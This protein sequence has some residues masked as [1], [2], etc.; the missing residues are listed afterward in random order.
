MSF[1][2]AGDEYA[3]P[4]ARV[5]ELAPEAGITPLPATPPFVLGLLSLHGAAVPVLDLQL[6]FRGTAAADVAHRS[7]LVLQLPIHGTCRLVGVAIDA[8]GRV[9]QVD[10]SQLQPPPALDTVISLEFLTG[11]LEREGRFLYALDVDRLLRADEAEAVAQLAEESAARPAAVAPQARRAF[12]SV[13]VA[14]E[15]CAVPL[16]SLDEI[17]PCGPIAR[18]P[19]APRHVLG[20]TNV[21]GTIVPVVDLP[22]RFLLQGAAATEDA[23]LLL[24]TPDGRQP[25]AARVDAVDGL[26]HV[27]ASEVDATPPFGARF[28]SEVVQAV[29]PLGGVF[30]PVLDIA[31]ALS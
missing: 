13:R 9:L 27:L 21:R 6:R 8:L 31:R 3:I 11:V 30:V 1:V 23:C 17:A 25:V 15:R 16:A 4:L 14:G 10:E 28:P 19:G 26:F 7:V 20:A 24:A 2:I 5:H 29:V 12:L 22:R 18:I